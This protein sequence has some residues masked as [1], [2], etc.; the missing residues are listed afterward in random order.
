MH[1]LVQRQDFGQI[2]SGTVSALHAAIH[3]AE[4]VAARVLAG[5]LQTAAQS[6]L[7]RHLEHRRVLPD[8]AARLAA[9]RVGIGGPEPGDHGVRIEAVCHLLRHLGKISRNASSADFASL[10]P[11]ITPRKSVM[12]PASPGWLRLDSQRVWKRRSE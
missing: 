3:E 4:E 10:M 5:K 8:L 6:G 11:G 1:L 2:G 7:C 9:E 12:I